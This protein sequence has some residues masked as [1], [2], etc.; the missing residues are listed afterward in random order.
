M[1]EEKKEVQARLIETKREVKKEGI[2]D[3]LKLI[4]PG[5]FLRTA[6]EGVQKAKTG[7]L[8]VVYNDFAQNMFEGGFKINSRFT[9]Q[10]IIE[11]GKMDGAII[12]SKDLKKIMNA[13]VLLTPDNSIP[14]NETG[15]RHKAAERTAKQAG[16]MVIAVSQRRDEISLF[17]KNLKYVVRDTND[18][19]RRA[20]S[21]LQIIEKHRDIFDKNKNELDR[22]ESKKKE[23][24]SLKALHMIQRGMIILKMSETLKGYIIELGAEGTL[25]KLRLKELLH[26]VEKDVDDVIS[27]Y[28]KIGVSKS[29]KILAILSYD[30]L[31]EFENIKQCLGISDEI[32]YPKGHR[33]LGKAGI[34]EE[35]TGALIKNFKNLPAILEAEKESLVKIFGEEKAQNVME[36][37][38][39]IKERE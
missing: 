36:K 9:P 20:T 33:M 35:D 10:R 14:S 7:G 11:L 23:D 4:S 24:S 15:T 16:T 18:I 30:E 27:D 26:R 21:V 3:V 17:Y 1:E 19:I 28:S 32:A 39:H 12:I 29:Q 5:T 8:I 34:C 25:V 13:N 31:L 2:T 22:H 38:S 6:I 37:I